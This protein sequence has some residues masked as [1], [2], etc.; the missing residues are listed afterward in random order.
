MV[1]M[2]P[3][4]FVAFLAATY[5]AIRVAGFIAHFIVLIYELATQPWDS[6]ASSL[7]IATVVF[8]IACI[9]M[10]YAIM[11][12]SDDH[13]TELQKARVSFFASLS[14]AA[15]IVGLFVVYVIAVK[16][17]QTALLAVHALNV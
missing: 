11:S 16:Q 17:R 1:S 4:V 15:G 6:I 13:K 10:A 12:S 9:V 14:Q 5:Y 2:N 8:L 3:F 7:M